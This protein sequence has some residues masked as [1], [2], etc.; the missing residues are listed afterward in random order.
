VAAA[1]NPESGQAALAKL[2]PGLFTQGS[3]DLAGSVTAEVVQ[4]RIDRNLLGLMWTQR[5]DALNGSGTFSTYLSFL[6][7][8]SLPSGS[9]NGSAARSSAVS[10]AVEVN[11][12]N[13]S[14]FMALAGDWANNSEYVGGASIVFLLSLPF[15]A[16]RRQDGRREKRL[17]NTL[18]LS[19]YDL[20]LLADLSKRDRFGSGS[21]I[22]RALE[23]TTSWGSLE[24]LLLQ[25]EGLGLYKRTVRLTKR[26]QVMLWERLI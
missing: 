20:S 18:G 15:E 19:E 11:A 21:D 17:E 23:G 24:R 25:F 2:H 22:M 5:V 1:P 3:Q 10:A 8:E 13:Q 16:A 12:S 26:R 14:W 4:S 9:V 7:I 6:T